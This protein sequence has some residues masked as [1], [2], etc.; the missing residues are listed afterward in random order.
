MPA[1]HEILT[2]TG[3]YGRADALLARLPDGPVRG[4]EVGVWRGDMSAQLLSRPDLFLYMVDSWAPSEEQPAAY[5]A[6]GDSHALLTRASQN[7]NLRLALKATEFAAARRSVLRIPSVEAAQLIPDQSLHFVFLDGDHSEDGTAADI[8]AWTPKIL[9]GGWL[10]GHDY[11]EAY[12][13]AQYDFRV[14]AAVDAAVALF[15]WTL[16]RDIDSTWFVRL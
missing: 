4:A 2:A 16:E 15:G 1:A 10:G 13:T 11:S 8:K 6:T 5:R 12:P 7:R 14:M 9:P 3:R